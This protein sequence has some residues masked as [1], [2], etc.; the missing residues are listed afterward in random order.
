M[1]PEVVIEDEQTPLKTIK[2]D[3]KVDIKPQLVKKSWKYWMHK[4]NWMMI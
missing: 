4:W 2:I 3:F 1:E